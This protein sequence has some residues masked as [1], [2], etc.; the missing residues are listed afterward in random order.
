MTKTKVVYL[1]EFN[2]F[3]VEDLFI[4]NH[5][6]SQNS[7]RS[8]HILKFKFQIIQTKFNGEITKAKVVCLD[9]LYNYYS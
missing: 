3:V 7:S 8:F 9:E 6:M 4:C 2:N 1:D 5:L